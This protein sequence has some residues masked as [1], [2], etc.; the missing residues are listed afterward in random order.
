MCLK[1]FQP[2]TR[3]THL[4]D[5]CF[6]NLT[7]KK[8]DLASKL[9]K[10]SPRPGADMDV[11][12]RLE[13]LRKDN[14]KFDDNNNNRPPLPPP[15]PPTFTSFIPPPPPTSPPSF[16][17]FQRNFQ[18]PPPPLHSPQLLHLPRHI[19]RV[20]PMAT[21]NQPTTHFGKMTITKTK[22][23]KEQILE[24]IGTAIYEVPVP[25]KIEIV[26]PFLNFLSTDAE[27]ILMN[28]M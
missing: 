10:K 21:K 24:D 25:P 15:S 3:K 23:E 22:P 5:R 2:L 1:T 13:A 20:R 8:K 7:S 6:E 9:I 18:A 4:F 17:S 19:P 11:Q 12:K 26:H 14:N 28:H 27:G 16:N